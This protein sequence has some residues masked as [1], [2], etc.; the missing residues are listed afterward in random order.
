MK[1]LL[2]FFSSLAVAIARLAR[3]LRG[4]WLRRQGLPTVREA[5]EAGK[6]PCPRVTALPQPPPL[7]SDPKRFHS[8]PAGARTMAGLPDDIFVVARTTILPPLPAPLSR[9]RPPEPLG[10]IG[11]ARPNYFGVDENGESAKR[12][13]E[14]PS[15]PVPPPSPP[16]IRTAARERPERP[17]ATFDPRRF[18]LTS[19][20]LPVTEDPPLPARRPMPLSRSRATFI[21]R[22]VEAEREAGFAPEVPPTQGEGVAAWAAERLDRPRPGPS[23]DILEW[24][25]E[26]D[27]V[28]NLGHVREQ[29]LLRRDVSRAEFD[30]DDLASP[31]PM[32]GVTLSS[33]KAFTGL[34][35][36]D[37]QPEPHES[38][39]LRLENPPPDMKPTVEEAQAQLAWLVRAVREHSE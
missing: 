2:A 16:P 20:A 37:L 35:F 17:L 30:A 13:R 33:M 21:A 34:T 10:E 11:V 28:E 8:V 1:G 25:Q 4:W 22:Y 5:L 9:V 7:P 15:V 36:E 39:K 38:L 19:E 26:E 24:E 3:R 27:V 12:E 18:G 29:F 23:G 6:L 31:E 14:T 32:A